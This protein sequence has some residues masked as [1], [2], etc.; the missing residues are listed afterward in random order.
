MRLRQV[1]G[2][3][4]GKFDLIRFVK[5]CIVGASGTLVNMSLLWLLTEFAGLPYLVSAAI[6]IETSI[7][8]NFT[9]HD[10]FTFSDRRSTTAMVFFRRLLKYNLIGLAGLAINMGVLWVL[11]ELVGLY[12]LLS[13][14]VGIAS[15]TV[16]RYILNLWWTWRSETG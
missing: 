5:F 14:L 7:V 6:S 11:T 1:F 10:F 3:V 12:Y 4:K 9:F 15:T 13:N 2:F 16:S 8:S